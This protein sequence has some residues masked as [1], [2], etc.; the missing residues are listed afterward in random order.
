MEKYDEYVV[1]SD[2]VKNGCLPIEAY[3]EKDKP[4]EEII[5][6]IARQVGLFILEDWSGTVIKTDSEFNLEEFTE[7]LRF[8]K[9]KLNGFNPYGH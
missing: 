8:S 3:V 9:I 7:E 4:Y 2:L 1:V 5:N 6:E